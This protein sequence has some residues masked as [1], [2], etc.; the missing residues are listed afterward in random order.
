MKFKHII[1]TCST[2]A[3]FLSCATNPFTGKQTMALVPNSQLFPTAF[4]QYNQVLAES[5]VET[6]TARADMITIVMVTM[7]TSWEVILPVRPLRVNMVLSNSSASGNGKNE[8]YSVKAN[9]IYLASCENFNQR[10]TTIHK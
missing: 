1:I 2:I 5:N 8:I 3:L 7:A 9:G 4:A 10:L 6:G